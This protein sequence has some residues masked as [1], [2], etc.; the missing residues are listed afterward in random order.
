MNVAIYY[1]PF[2]GE[3]HPDCEDIMALRT[4]LT[5]TQSVTVTED[6]FEAYW[7]KVGED[8]VDGF[9]DLFARWNAGSGKESPA[10]A[11]RECTDCDATFTGEQDNGNVNLEV[12]Q[13]DANAHET[14]YD[15][16]E[17]GRGT[18]SLSCGDIA[19]NM[20]TGTAFICPPFG[21]WEE[22]DF[23]VEA[24]DAKTAEV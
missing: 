8:T 14:V 11:R 12:R 7:E 9:E 1:L 10:F 5:T 19:V 15:G 23:T 16:H 18:R 13:H 6:D 22:L 2:A 21:S 20:E 4:A 17:V 3:D 24:D